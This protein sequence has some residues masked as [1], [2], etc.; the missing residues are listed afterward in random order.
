[1]HKPLSVYHKKQACF[2]ASNCTFGIF[3]A[4]K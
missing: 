2:D 3:F 1:M 4:L